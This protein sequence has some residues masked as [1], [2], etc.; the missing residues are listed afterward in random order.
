MNIDGKQGREF[1]FGVKSSKWFQFRFYFSSRIFQKLR[2][3]IKWD[4]TIGCVCVCVCAGSQ[5]ID[6]GDDRVWWVFLKLREEKMHEA[7][8]SKLKGKVKHQEH[9]VNSFSDK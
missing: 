5:W 1:F 8:I 9:I 3:Q 6:D 4:Y 7:W 2:T